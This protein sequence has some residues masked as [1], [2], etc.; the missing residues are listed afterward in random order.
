[1]VFSCVTAVELPRPWL[2]GGLWDTIIPSL[3][4]FAAVMMTKFLVSYHTVTGWNQE[5][6]SEESTA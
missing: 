2:M 5:K 4:S 1:M 6:R 3:S